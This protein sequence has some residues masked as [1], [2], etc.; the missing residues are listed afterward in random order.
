MA[1]ASGARTM[2]EGNVTINFDDDSELVLKPSLNAIQTLSRKYGGVL[3]VIERLN[4]LDFDVCIE[5]I[6]LGLG[7]PAS[8]KARQ[9]LSEKI[10]L[11][12]MTDDTGRV[13]ERCIDYIRVLMRGGRAEQAEDTEPKDKAPGN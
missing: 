11:H 4:R 9:E 7:R 12:G 1:N 10:Y 3:N 5:V 2:G 13:P 6:E 8:P